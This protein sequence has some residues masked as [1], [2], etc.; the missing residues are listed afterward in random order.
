MTKLAC[1]TRY[2]IKTY[3]D[4]FIKFVYFPLF[5]EYGLE[6]TMNRSLYLQTVDLELCSVWYKT[7]TFPTYLGVRKSK[8]MKTEIYMNS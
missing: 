6:N 3:F 7:Y 2:Q 8:K 1:F 4:I 5:F